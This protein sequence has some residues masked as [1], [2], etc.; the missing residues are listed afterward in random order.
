ICWLAAALLGF[1]LLLANMFGYLEVTLPAMLLSCMT[2]VVTV[3]FYLK[4][5]NQ[6]PDFKA[7]ARYIEEHQPDLKV[8][9][10]TAVDQQPLTSDNTYNYLQE[11]VIDQAVQHANQNNWLKVISNRKLE[12]A[13]YGRW[14]TGLLFIFIASQLFPPI[15]FVASDGE[16]LADNVYRLLVNPGNAEIELGAP[17][18][19]TARFEGKVPSD[20]TLIM[21]LSPEETERIPLSKNLDDPVY[22]TIIPQVNQNIEYRI[23]YDDHRSVDF[24][25]SVYS[26]PELVRADAQIIYPE[27][28]DLEEK[29]VNDTRQISV[30]E[31]SQVNFT[32]KLNKPVVDAHL[33]ARDGSVHVLTVDPDDPESYLVQLEPRQTQRYDL[34]LIDAQDRTNKVPPRIT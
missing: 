9:L 8:L 18:V 4:S 31:G 29:I 2:V 16:V 14:A 1:M 23:E 5:R 30:L 19:I 7:I 20:A 25:L 13:N 24:L 10:L 27:Y 17:V 32:F 11:R 34:E 33:K 12:W 26:Y 3:Y 6:R 22:G 15:S 28:A 21:N